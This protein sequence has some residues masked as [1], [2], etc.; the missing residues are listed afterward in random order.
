M[1][2]GAEFAD[3]VGL[4]FASIISPRGHAS[5]VS[6]PKI[7]SNDLNSYNLLKTAKLMQRKKAKDKFCEIFGFLPG[8]HLPISYPT[9]R[10]SP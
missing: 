9:G 4:K 10:K 3:D 8:K 6:P 1:W 2:V 5:R 7:R